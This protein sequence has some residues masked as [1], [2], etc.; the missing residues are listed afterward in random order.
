MATK[1]GKFQ[2]KIGYKLTLLVTRILPRFLHQTVY[3]CGGI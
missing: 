3:L 1:I 2:Q